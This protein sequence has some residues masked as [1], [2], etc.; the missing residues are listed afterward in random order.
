MGTAPSNLDIT[1][2]GDV[3][4]LTQGGRLIDRHAAFFSISLLLGYTYFF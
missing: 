2:T 3:F 1:A 4:G